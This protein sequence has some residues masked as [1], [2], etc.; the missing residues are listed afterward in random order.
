LPL[1]L[2]LPFLQEICRFLF[3]GLNLLQPILNFLEL[4]GFDG[5]IGGSGFAGSIFDKHS[6]DP[7]MDS[8]LTLRLHDVADRNRSHVAAVFEVARGDH[9]VQDFVE[10]S[11]LD[12]VIPKGGRTLRRVG[13]DEDLVVFVDV[14]SI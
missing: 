1:V 3:R 12:L 7:Q 11:P 5:A 6:C 4:A 13:S 2:F 14:R 9:V 10:D 8:R